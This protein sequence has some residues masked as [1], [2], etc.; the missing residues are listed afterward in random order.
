MRKET[1]QLLNHFNYNAEMKKAHNFD[2]KLK[3]KHICEALKAD[4]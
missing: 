3:F 2:M 1:K 4:K